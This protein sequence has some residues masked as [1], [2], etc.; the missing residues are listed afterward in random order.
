MDFKKAFI[1]V[2][3]AFF[4]VIV[5][6]LFDTKSI[7]SI[8]IIVFLTYFLMKYF[9]EARKSEQKEDKKKVSLNDIPGCNVNFFKSVLKKKI[10]NFDKNR[11]LVSFIDKKINELKHRSV[12]YVGISLKDLSEYYNLENPLKGKIFAK[13]GFF[14]KELSDFFDFLDNEG[15]KYL[16]KIGFEKQ[17]NCR[18]FLPVLVEV[19][20]PEINF[21]E[22][23]IEI[24]LVGNKYSG[25]VNLV[26]KLFELRKIV[27]NA[28]GFYAI[29]REDGIK[30]FFGFCGLID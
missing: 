2:S 22:R 13:K 12:K 28:G 24:I 19:T 7:F 15:I 10:V 16:F 21:S 6:I 27:E 20:L 5:D 1:A 26:R 11:F 18:G 30:V 29:V 25:K 23:Q 3:V 14:E 4:T 8:I 17:F 9:E